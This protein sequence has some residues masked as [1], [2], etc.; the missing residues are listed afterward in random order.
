MRTRALLLLNRLRVRFPIRRR[1]RSYA[2]VFPERYRRTIALMR[3]GLTIIGLLLSF[4]VFGS[5]WIS[6]GVAL[7]IAIVGAIVNNSLF[8]YTS[9]YIYPF[10]DFDLVADKWLGCFFGFERFQNN[11]HDA[12]VMGITLDDEEYAQNI[13]RLILAWAYGELIDRDRNLRVDVIVY[14]NSYVLFLY[15]RSTRA[16]ATRFFRQTASQRRRVSPNDVQDRLGVFFVLGKRF[17]LQPESSYF[18]TF[19]K[20]YTKGV[21]VILSVCVADPSGNPVPIPGLDDLIIYSLRIKDRQDLKP[22]DLPYQ[23]FNIVGQ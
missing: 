5:V 18:P 7:A 19:R 21:P 15:P 16:S 3:H 11:P 17:L 10:P 6:F 2:I 9:M 22:T 23:I 20:R 12:P 13:H 8:S 4:V 1:G 14:E